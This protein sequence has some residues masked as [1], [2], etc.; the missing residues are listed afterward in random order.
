MI[1][2]EY[3]WYYNDTSNQSSFYYYPHAVASTQPI[4][5]DSNELLVQSA[6]FKDI[7]VWQYVS[8]VH[9]KTCR[10]WSKQQWAGYALLCVSEQ[11]YKSVSMPTCTSC[12]RALL[13]QCASCLA[14]GGKGSLI[15]HPPSLANYCL[16]TEIDKP[17]ATTTGGAKP[18]G[19]AE[20]PGW[21]CR[22]EKGM[23]FFLK[24]R[25][26]NIL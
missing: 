21:R 6:L 4:K 5:L 16:L 23:S 2:E 19:V 22:A 12:R 10:D 8:S 14:Q 18:I 24:H 15:T 17:I 9:T 7:C 13:S 11:L 1:R 3:T 25:I 26:V 20:P